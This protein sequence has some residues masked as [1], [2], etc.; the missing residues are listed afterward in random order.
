VDD[1][2]RS[3]GRVLRLERP[4]LRAVF[5]IDAVDVSAK[6]PLPAPEE[7]LPVG[8]GGRGLGVSLHGEVPDLSAGGFIEAVV[9]VAVP[10]AGEDLPLC[11]DRAS[12]YG[13]SSRR[14]SE[15]PDLIAGGGVET[16][17]PH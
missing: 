4:Y 12:V 2:C 8:Y 5:E 14:M 9:V 6:P 7:N 1:G 10:V 3:A 16:D 11:H 17:C 15:A 13:A